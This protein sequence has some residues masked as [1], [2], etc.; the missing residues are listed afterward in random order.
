M[1]NLAVRIIT[2]EPLRYVLSSR[3][4]GGVSDKIKKRTVAVVDK[5]N[6]RRSGKEKVN[7]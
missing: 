6:K 1:L 5:S 3:W 2:T 7:L 4:R